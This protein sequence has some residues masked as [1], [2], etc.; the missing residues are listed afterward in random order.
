MTCKNCGKEGAY[1]RKITR[2]YGSG[3]RLVVIEN[4]PVISCRNCG[5]DLLDDDTLDRLYELR[6][7]LR[8]NPANIANRQLVKVA[9]FQEDP[10]TVQA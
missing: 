6:S 8:A 7:A 4:V 1:I 3:D 2:A 9:D 10:V 5:V